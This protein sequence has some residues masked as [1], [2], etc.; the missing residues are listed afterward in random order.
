MR[1]LSVFLAALFLFA[2]PALAQRT[3]VSGTVKDVNGVA[4]AGGTIQA[5]L[6][7]PVGVSG[8]TLNGAQIAGTTPRVTL[9]NTGSFLM[10]LPDNA[11]VQPGG[12]QWTFNVNI[13]PGAPP[14][15]GTGPQTCSATLTITG[16][17]Q[18]V[19]AS[20][21]A[22]PALGNSSGGTIS[23]SVLPLTCNNGSLYQVTGSLRV[24]S[25]SGNV[26]SPTDGTG[27]IY[28]IDYVGVA[29]LGAFRICQ[30]TYNGTTTV[31]SGASDPPFTAAM[32]GWKYEGTNQP[33][34]GNGG[35]LSSTL[36]VSS[37]TTITFVNAHQITLS[38]AAAGSAGNGSTCCYG[39]LGPKDIG[40][41]LQ[42]FFN[43]VLA[44]CGHTGILYDGG[45]LVGNFISHANPQVCGA[46]GGFDVN[47]Q[48]Y[49]IKGQ[50]Q[51][52]TTLFML[53]TL[54]CA[55]LPDAI[56]FGAANAAQ[57]VQISDFSVDGGGNLT[58]VNANCG[59]KNIFRLGNASLFANIGGLQWGNV[60]G[61]NALAIGGVFTGN[62][63]N[64]QFFNFGN[65]CAGLGTGTAGVLTILNLECSSPGGATLNITGGGSVVNSVGSGW[66][67][68]AGGAAL[69]VNAGSGTFNSKGDIITGGASGQNGLAVGSS[70]VVNLDGDTIT[71]GTSGIVLNTGGTPGIVHLKDTSVSGTGSG[72]SGGVAGS[73]LFD[74]CGNTFQATNTMANIA[75]LGTC[76]ITG[77]TITAAK[78]VLS[79]GWGASAAWTALTG[80]TQLVQGT[81]TNTGA[82]QAANPT[83][84][85]TFPTPF[86]VA[87]DV[88]TAYQVGGTQPIVAAAEFL[89]PSSVT[90]T[91]VV[92]TYNGTPTVNLTEVIQIRCGS[93]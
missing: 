62:I 38:S 81:I 93:I 3:V 70:A 16:A 47:Q 31:T 63:E 1:R 44:V 23:V 69:T 5:L 79:A 7:L 39:I 84:T 6:S 80:N 88:C 75:V 57:S 87:P 14:P 27:S 21:S 30:A 13:S 10:Q 8:A 71:A 25:C 4:Y 49:T 24:Y 54:S 19:S 40:P 53:D 74:E 22:C 89:T 55:G 48:G 91:G 34:A 33:C 67:N 59:S 42:N 52:S 61:L 92:F 65:T 18:S 29:G 51:N 56:L 11:V 82:G 37:T 41:Q 64:V 66:A 85:Y 90:N 58:N 17:S 9:D 76:S 72:I 45:G 50:S 86:L 36:E 26:L 12:T 35:T 60:I 20:F 83:I 46:V 43:A 78:L 2:V 73:K 32:N 77:T 68:V 15:L 28:A